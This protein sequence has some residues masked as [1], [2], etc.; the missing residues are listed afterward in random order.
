MCF[1]GMCEANCTANSTPFGEKAIVEQTRV[2]KF[3]YVFSQPS[4]KTATWYDNYICHFAEVKRK[5]ESK[6][7]FRILQFNLN[8]YFQFID[9]RLTHIINNVCL[10]WCRRIKTE[11]RS[12]GNSLAVKWVTHT[13]EY[14]I[15]TSN[16]F[17]YLRSVF[18]K[19]NK[20][21]IYHT[22]VFEGERKRERERMRTEKERE[23][24]SV[25]RERKR[26]VEDEIE[27]AYGKRESERER[28]TDHATR[29]RECKDRLVICL[30][31]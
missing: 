9:C 16:R 12:C 19:S 6:N 20:V 10:N 11:K 3:D 31:I 29:E 4:K 21:Y 18:W 2:R 27:R 8:H 28:A 1:A 24:E 13:P 7:P 22:Y 15:I 30:G 26:E 14:D 17:Q 25:Y 23:K 5:N